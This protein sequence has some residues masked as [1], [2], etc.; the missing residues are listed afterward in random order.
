MPNITVLVHPLQLFP[1]SLIVY[2]H[3]MIIATFNYVSLVL[4][5]FIFFSLVSFRLVSFRLVSFR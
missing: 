3:C 1:T 5:S 2:C 4:F